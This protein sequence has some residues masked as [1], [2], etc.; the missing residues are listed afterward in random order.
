MCPRHL[1][2]KWPLQVAVTGQMA[3]DLWPRK[4]QLA[5]F[6][7]KLSWRNY[8]AIPLVSLPFSLSYFLSLSLLLS[9]SCCHSLKQLCRNVLQL[10]ILTNHQLR[11]E[12]RKLLVVLVVLAQTLPKPCLKFYGFDSLTVSLSVG[13]IHG[14]S[15]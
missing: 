15:L 12:S 2:A 9:L 7:P 10:G 3:N 11:I 4:E 1:F 5:P 8:L 14:R 13:N 6:V